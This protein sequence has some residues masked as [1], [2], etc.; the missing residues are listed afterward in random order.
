[1]KN[2]NKLI[3]VLA[4]LSTT[5]FA[6]TKWNFDNS[7]S[8][9]GFSVTHMLI[10]ET[11]GYFKDYS[12]SIVSSND[13]FQ[14]AVI[15]FEAKTASIFTDNEKRDQHLISDDFF[16]AEKFPMLNFESTS[17]TKVD[18]KNYK[19]V[20][21]LT[22]KGVTKEVTLA[23]KYNG[24]ITDPW[25]NTRAGFK[26]SGDIDRFDYGLTWNAAL[27]AGGLVVGKEVELDIKVEVLKEK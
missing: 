13:D 10:S 18:G 16:D 17:F 11:D 2:I 21:N 8:Q 25:G 19:L 23:A 5:L 20:G 12:G 9:I 14:N 6:Q 15:K 3:V 22:I 1:M 24:T 4:L 7:H 27:E 26:I